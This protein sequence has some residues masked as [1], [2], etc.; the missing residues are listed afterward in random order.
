MPPKVLIEG[1]ANG[2]DQ[3]KIK[4][5]AHSTFKTSDN[6]AGSKS[7]TEEDAYTNEEMEVS[8]RE[9]FSSME[10]KNDDL[11]KEGN[12]QTYDVPPLLDSSSKNMDDPDREDKSMSYITPREEDEQEEDL[13][14]IR[15]KD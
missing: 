9:E 7:G 4:Y 5:K 14:M 1:R 15:K 8:F 13:N 11:S 6:E 12:D 3:V 2:K 10:I